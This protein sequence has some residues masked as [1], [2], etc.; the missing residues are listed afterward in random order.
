VDDVINANPLYS[1]ING[2]EVTSYNEK[3]FRKRGKLMDAY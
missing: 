3:C 1:S 2:D